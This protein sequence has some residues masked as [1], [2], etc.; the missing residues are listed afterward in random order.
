MYFG[1]VTTTYAFSFFTPTILKQLGWTAVR[2]QVMSIPIYI[3]AMALSLATAVVSDRL[4]HRF[5]FTLAGCLVATVG[6]IL[7]LC[8]QSIPVAARY[9]ALYAV[10][11]GGFIT[12]AILL[13]LVS[14]N[15]AGHY[16]IS[17]AAAVQVGFG[18]CSG[19]VASN[20]FEEEAP[21]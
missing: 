16:K 7:L 17:I 21:T 4:R 10:T 1:I 2:A 15:V 18:N 6:Y 19:L 9:F 13:G 8:Q 5:A 12:Q 3:F 14:N 20:I 11:G